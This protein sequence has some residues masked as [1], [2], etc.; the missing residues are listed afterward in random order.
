MEE[1]RPHFLTN[2]ILPNVNM[3]CVLSSPDVTGAAVPD[4]LHGRIP[5]NV[6]PRESR[7]I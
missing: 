6:G 2:A 7:A 5:S 4:V 1:H 3:G